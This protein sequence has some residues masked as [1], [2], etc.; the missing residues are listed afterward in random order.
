MLYSYLNRP[1][2]NTGCESCVS[3]LLCDS[4]AD[5]AGTLAFSVHELEFY[6]LNVVF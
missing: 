1:V 2:L 6:L 5:T 4:V 3:E